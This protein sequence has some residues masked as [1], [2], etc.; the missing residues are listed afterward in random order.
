MESNIGCN[1]EHQTHWRDAS[2]SGV[3]HRESPSTRRMRSM[4]Q[5]KR[6]DEWETKPTSNLKG[7]P[8]IK[9]QEKER[10]QPQ[11][12]RSRDIWARQDR[13]YA[14][15]TPCPRSLLQGVQPLSCSKPVL[16]NPQLEQ[17]AGMIEA[18]TYHQSCQQESHL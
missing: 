2:K 1:A 17:K 4:E 14:C 8:R 15:Q 6:G 10:R 9:M 16:K 5:M 11:S 13:D 12:I 18:V 7:C 3:Q